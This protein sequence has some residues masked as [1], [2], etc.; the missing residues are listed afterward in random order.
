MTKTELIEE[1]AVRADLPKAKVERLINTLCDVVGERLQAGEKVMLPPLGRFVHVHRAARKA[2]NPLT[3]EKVDV[4]ER[5]A[6]RFQASAT[7]KRRLN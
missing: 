2:R 5:A 4:P 1:L 7:L 6:V 3:G